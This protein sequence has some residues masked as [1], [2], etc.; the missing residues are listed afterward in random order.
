MRPLFA[1]TTLL[2]AVAGLT[3]CSS[4]QAGSAVF[5]ADGKTVLA[6]PHEGAALWSVSTTDGKTTVLDLGKA[7]D[8]GD[9]IAISQ[10]A[11]GKIWLATAQKLFLWKP[12]SDT[13]EKVL[14]IEKGGI[15]DIQWNPATGD[16][17]LECYGEDVADTTQ[18]HLKALRKGT[19]ELIKA[20]DAPMMFASTFDA[21]GRM[22]FSSDSDLWAGL[23]DTE[24]DVVSLT[25]WRAAPLA[26]LQY[27]AG[28]P[29]SSFTLMDLACAGKSLFMVVSNEVE[30]ML[31]QMTKPQVHLGPESPLEKLPI[32]VPA[33]WKQAAATLQSLKEVPV[34]GAVSTIFHLCASPDGSQVF[35]LAYADE[36]GRRTFRLLDVKTGKIKILAEAPGEG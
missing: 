13:A 1:L 20:E 16:L 32:G 30:A 29:G 33:S 5:M 10:G 23:P 12:G 34:T 6:C 14:V 9:L 27:D 11:E 8:G 3:F 36:D 24:N 2:A 18:P 25:A 22:Y 26:V 31:V 19:K 15:Q 4:L 35:F 17:F 21:E 7:L 28:S